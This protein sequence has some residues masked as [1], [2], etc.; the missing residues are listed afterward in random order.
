MKLSLTITT[1]PARRRMLAGLLERLGKHPD[2]TIR[3]LTDQVASGRIGMW[4]R[5]MRPAW[6][7]IDRT[8]THHCVMEDDLDLCRDFLA[9][10]LLLIDLY[11]EIPIVP[12]SARKITLKARDRGAHLIRTGVFYG[13][14][15]CAPVALVGEYIA[16]CDKM[17]VDAAKMRGS[18]SLW[19]DFARARRIKALTTSPSLIQHVGKRS[20]LWN[21]GLRN[22]VSQYFVGADRSGLEIDW[23]ASEVMSG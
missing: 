9:T 21:L 17:S 10:L 14:C 23:A 2:V 5:F 1:I 15:I 18:D 8:A 11:P 19:A 12:Y 4:D 22:R 6:A 7:G 3:V 13:V 20:A 16:W